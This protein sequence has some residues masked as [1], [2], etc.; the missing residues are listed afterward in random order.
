MESTYR[1]ILSSIYTTRRKKNRSYSLAAFSRDCGFESYHISDIIK[2]R[3]GL[4]L[5]S[6][7]KVANRLRMPADIRCEFL[8][9][10][11][12]EVAK[13]PVDREIAKSQ[14]KQLRYRSDKIISADEF[15]QV[16]EWYHF[17]ICELARKPQEELD[18][19]DLSE[20][21]EITVKQAKDAVETL[22]RLGILMK[23]RSRGYTVDYKVLK[24]QTN[25]TPNK[26]RTYHKDIISKALVAM[27][28][29]PVDQRFFS[30]FNG[31]LTEA[32]YQSLT[33]DIAAFIRKR[34]SEVQNE[35]RKHSHLYSVGFQVCPLEVKRKEL[36]RK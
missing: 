34:L 35:D 29:E 3:Y 33:E 6:A 2:G 28:R 10:V 4:S 36:S 26:I 20:R 22:C 11:Q 14:L 5:R 23:N 16:G 27:E 31:L 7:E 17:A 32:E 8:D 1:D 21:L 9:L 12:M 30:T 18:P 25:T 19:Q 24:Y 15:Q 13:S